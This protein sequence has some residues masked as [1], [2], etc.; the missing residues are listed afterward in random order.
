[1]INTHDCTFLIGFKNVN[2][3]KRV[4]TQNS[5]KRTSR[6]P[7]IIIPAATTSL[8]TMVNVKDILQDLKFVSNEEKKKQGITRDNEVLLQVI[9]LKT[10]LVSSVNQIFYLKRKRNNMTVP[11]RVIDN[12]QKLTQ[13]DWNRVVAVFVMGPAWQFK[14][15]PWDG[16]PVEIFSK[17][18]FNLF[19]KFI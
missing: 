14:G 19:F 12:P 13:Q 8:I 6:T 1:M 10:Q 4:I 7:I 2:I 3:N 5:Q 9:E 11:Y 18:E 17:S 15:W 16:N